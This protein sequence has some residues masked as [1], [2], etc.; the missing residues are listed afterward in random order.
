MGH[1]SAT[2]YCERGGNDAMNN[3][4]AIKPRKMPQDRNLGWILLVLGLGVLALAMAALALGRYYVSLE[5]VMRILGS[6]VWPLEQTWDQTMH[7]VV[8][9]LRVPRVLAAVLVGGAISLAGVTYEGMFENVGLL[10]YLG[11]HRDLCGLPE[12]FVGWECQ[13]SLRFLAVWLRILDL[14]PSLPL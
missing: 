4:G 1:V 2:I 14:A 10:G 3:K 13:I 8:M 7:D 12:Q 5:E 11:Y 6:Q 9:N